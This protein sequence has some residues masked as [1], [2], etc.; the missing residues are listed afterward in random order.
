MASNQTISNIANILGMLKEFNEPYKEAESRMREMAFERDMVELKFDQQKELSKDAISASKEFEKWKLT[1]PTMIA[2][3]KRISQEAE[4]AR[5]ETLANARKVATIKVEGSKEVAKLETDYKNEIKDEINS[6]ALDANT[7]KIYNEFLQKDADGLLTTDDIMNITAPTG[8]NLFY[9]T[10]GDAMYAGAMDVLG[11]AT[12]G[13]L[14]YKAI[15]AGQ[16]LM[17]APSIYT[18][19][20]GAGLIAAGG[21]GGYISAKKAAS[22]AGQLSAGAGELLEETTEEETNFQRKNA[23]LS[24]IANRSSVINE[25]SQSATQ[26]QQ[27]IQSDSISGDALKEGLL[28]KIDM[29]NQPDLENMIIRYGDDNMLEDYNNQNNMLNVI[30]PILR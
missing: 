5:D 17:K 7:I 15:T 30:M 26:A 27:G 9:D 6:Q 4:D 11:G 28:N 24:A 12:T 8:R 14:S 29:V 23:L 3:Q 10:N 18:K 19:V 20:A 21:V 22:V 1:D 2:E 25:I 13:G 16:A